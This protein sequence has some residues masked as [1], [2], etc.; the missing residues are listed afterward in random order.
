VLQEWRNGTVKS[1]QFSRDASGELPQ[2][3]HDFWPEAADGTA[4]HVVLPQSAVL[5]RRVWLP[6][7][8]AKDL[9]AVVELQLE[10][11]LPVP[12]DQVHADWHIEA[13]DR[14]RSRIE[15]AIAIAWRREIEQ[16]LDAL[17]RWQ[18]R[19]VAIGVDLEAGAAVFNLSPHRARRSTG[20]LSSIDRLLSVGAAVL[21]LAYAGIVGS[22]WLGERIAVERELSRTRAAAS[23][24]ERALAELAGRRE[25]LVRLQRLMAAASSAEI[26]SALTAAVPHDSWLQ[27]L[28]IRCRDDGDCSIRFTAA[29]SAVAALVQH[30]EQSPYFENVELQSSTATGSTTV[31][32]RAEVSAD[33]V[34]AAAAQAVAP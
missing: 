2:E 15:V 19:V 33:W 1:A 5:I 21:A 34:P 16:L 9:A 30:L 3:R 18:L 29:T 27:Q 8:A 13:H 23:R 22:Q 6:A 4:V 32:D 20:K 10:R 24:V 26:L 14:D 31:H 28:D 25:P 7:E 11:E 12:R 17:N